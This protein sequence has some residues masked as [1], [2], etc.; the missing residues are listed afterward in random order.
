[1]AAVSL[2][3]ATAAAGCNAVSS[4]LQRK[5]NREESPDLP[6]GFRLIVHLL[7]RP[8]WL[9]GA[10]A[11][12][13]SFLLQAVALGSGTLSSVEPVLALE[14]PLTLIIGSVVFRHR[15]GA[16]DWVSAAAMALGL[17]LFIGALS[18]SGGDAARIGE[19]LAVLATLATLAGVA[20][21]ALAG[22]F[23]PQRS[24]AALF[25][26]AAGS[27][28]G[29]TA[30][31]IKVSVSRL[32]SDGVSGLFSTWETYGFAITGVGSVVLV[33]AAL[34]AGTLVAVQPGLTLLDPLVS[35]LWG[36]VV[37]GERTRTGVALLAAAAG[38]A[39][40]AVSVFTLARSSASSMH[41]DDERVREVAR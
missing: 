1:M 5:A 6:F 23:G 2:G 11:M 14:L 27:G 18:P 9:F 17:G 21:L 15:L 37:L 28:F 4:V 10:L 8:I 25:G 19:G 35:L 30:C 33:Q 29:L 12:V 38:A 39:V 3:L 32:S 41:R 36:T 26:A 22:Q 31:L 34:H 40:I 7:R 20:A 13:A 16:R 24:R